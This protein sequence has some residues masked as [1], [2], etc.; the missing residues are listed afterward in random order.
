MTQP[1]DRLWSYRPPKGSRSCREVGGGGSMK[2]SWNVARVG[3]GDGMSTSC[4][5]SGSTGQLPTLSCQAR[6]LHFT[7]YSA[8]TAVRRWTQPHQAPTTRAWADCITS[9][10]T[11]MKTFVKCKKFAKTYST[12]MS[13]DASEESTTTKGS[14]APLPDPD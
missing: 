11:R 6:S 3:P 1:D 2:P 4:R 8:M 13:R 9:S 10:S 5:P 12:A 14:D 7:Y